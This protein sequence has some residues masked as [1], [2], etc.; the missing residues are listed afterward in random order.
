MRIRHPISFWLSIGLALV[1][2][3]LS[4]ALHGFLFIFAVID[5]GLILA[6]PSVVRKETK[7][8]DRHG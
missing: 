5:V 6:L 4:V 2:A 3:L 7:W 8:L 1:T